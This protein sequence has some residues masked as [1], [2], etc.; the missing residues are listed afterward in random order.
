MQILSQKANLP[1]LLIWSMER[2]KILQQEFQACKSC[3]F[4]K[5]SSGGIS[6]LLLFSGVLGLSVTAAD[7]FVGILKTGWKQAF[8]KGWG[9]IRWQPWRVRSAV[10]PFFSKEISHMRN[11]EFQ[12]TEEMFWTVGQTRSLL[13]SQHKPLAD[14]WVSCRNSVVVSVWMQMK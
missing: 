8:C 6:S 10:Q 5:L 12:H 13:K 9:S 11:S 1:R 7:S 4:C 14:F 2:E 3:S